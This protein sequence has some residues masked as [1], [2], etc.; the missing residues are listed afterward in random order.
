M[1]YLFTLNIIDL[2]TAILILIV[3]FDRFFYSFSIVKLNS[4]ISNNKHLPNLIKNWFN[5]YSIRSVNITNKFTLVMFIVLSCLF[6]FTKF[7][8]IRI[9]SELNSNLDDYV[10]VYNYFKNMN[11]SYIYFFILKSNRTALLS[12]KFFF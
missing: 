12:K 1:G 10:I 11:K 6:I 2:I 4:F 9:T 7:I 5:K 3:I 8:S